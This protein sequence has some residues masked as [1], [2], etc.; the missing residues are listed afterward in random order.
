M[1][2]EALLPRIGGAPM[3]PRFD[4][5]PSTALLIVDSL[6]LPVGHG[7]WVKS[8]LPFPVHIELEYWPKVKRTNEWEE[9]M[10]DEF[11][12]LNDARVL[13]PQW[14]TNEKGITVSVDARTNFLELLDEGQYDKMV[15]ALLQPS[16]GAAFDGKGVAL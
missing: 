13:A 4:G 14:L 1:E 2:D 12:I 11:L 8:T 9:P 5:G 10:S 3:N 15:Y 6:T 7:G 16:E